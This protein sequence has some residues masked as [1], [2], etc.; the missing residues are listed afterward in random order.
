MSYRAGAL[1][2]FVF[3]YFRDPKYRD[4]KRI[5]RMPRGFALRQKG[6]FMV[7]ELLRL[8]ENEQ[9]G[10]GILPYGS[11][12]LKKFA[13]GTKQTL[14]MYREVFEHMLKNAPDS[15]YTLIAADNLKKFYRDSGCY[16][17]EKRMANFISLSMQ[18]MGIPDQGSV[19]DTHRGTDPIPSLW[20]L[21]NYLKMKAQYDERYRERKYKKFL[22]LLKRNSAN[23]ED[24]LHAAIELISDPDSRISSTAIILAAKIFMLNG[25]YCSSG[26]IIEQFRN[27][28][29]DIV[30][31][32]PCV[33]AIRI[34]L[35]AV[36][37]IF[38][39]D[40][41]L[42]F[43][44]KKYFTDDLDSCIATGLR[45]DKEIRFKNSVFKVWCY[46]IEGKR[47]RAEKMTL[48]LEKIAAK[49]PHIN[50]EYNKLCA[51]KPLIAPKKYDPCKLRKDRLYWQ[52]FLM[53][54]KDELHD[55]NAAHAKEILDNIPI[56]SPP[57]DRP[58][59]LTYLRD[60]Y[61]LADEVCTE[62][63]LTQEA[64]EAEKKHRYLAKRIRS[65][66]KRGSFIKKVSLI[67]E[68]TLKTNDFGCCPLFIF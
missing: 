12:Q 15:L 23:E 30:H 7:Q 14:D 53:L 54:A 26:R 65:I 40:V 51:L 42:E 50:E 31:R 32:V 11:P 24:L 20:R 36:D 47:D 28:M 52:H 34:P 6:V 61:L 58:L 2:V 59:Y 67:T 13:K 38:A 35:F 56:N 17:E 37:P 43:K 16:N 63:M 25:W 19:C 49:M 21:D 60:Y 66:D 62:L 64:S 39:T 48:M 9:Y 41:F 46:L 22:H 4:T 8:L 68:K 18:R 57:F 5:R 33:P 45:P 3:A 44:D 55:G 27:R 10:K 1:Y 29:I